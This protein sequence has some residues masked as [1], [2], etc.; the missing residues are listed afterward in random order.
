LGNFIPL[1]LFLLVLAAVVREG[2][3]VTVLFLLAGVYFAGHWWSRRA[4]NAVT[5]SR[6]FTPRAFPGETVRV[7][8]E[9][10]NGGLLPVPW[11]Q[12]QDSTAPELILTDAFRRVITLGGHGR[13]QFEYILRAH[14][15]G[16]YN[17]GPL[18]LNSGDLIGLVG[19]LSRASAADHLTVYPRIIPLARFSLPSR[20]PLGPL[21]HTQPLY[22]DPARTFGKRDY[23]GGD[24]L[25]RVDWKATAAV[26]RLQVKQFE[27][28]IAV[29]SALFL[30]LNSNEYDLRSR[31]DSS[32]LA[33]VIAASIA[34]WAVANKQTVGLFT[35]GLDP[36][37][38]RRGHSERSA[39]QSKNDPAAPVDPNDELHPG[40][41]GRLPPHKGRGHLIRLLEVLARVQIGESIPFAPML[42]RESARLSWG[43]TL[44]VITSLLNDALFDALFTAHRAGLNPMVITVVADRNFREAQRRAHHFGIAAYQITRERDLD[45]WRR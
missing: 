39:A 25:R 4:L 19:D 37:A 7:R 29:E 16:Y 14:K 15:R 35:N 5:F 36:L 8:L 28:S 41:A 9:V 34:N 12:L 42:I 31:I 32:E 22:E 24:S 20:S 3:L 18:F 13:A 21:K 23:V 45:I 44:V 2:S 38:A 43:T 10:A 17:V 27:P 6:D 26:G 40:R 30:N 11:L 33:I 1:L